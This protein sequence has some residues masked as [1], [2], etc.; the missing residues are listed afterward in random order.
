MYLYRTSRKINLSNL[1]KTVKIKNSLTSL[2][3]VIDALEDDKMF[4]DA[5]IIA[6]NLADHQQISEF[7]HALF[8][9]A[10]DGFVQLRMFI[11]DKGRGDRA[12]LYGYPWRAVHVGDLDK[13]AE[14]AAQVASFAA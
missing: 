11:D 6:D 2:V 1:P 13:L 10:D 3:E 14:I 7:V 5:N 4:D 9:H 8:K 12:S